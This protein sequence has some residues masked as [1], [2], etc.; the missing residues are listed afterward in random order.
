[1]AFY[2]RYDDCIAEFKAFA[3]GGDPGIE[4]LNK[5]W[6][7][8]FDHYS[9]DTCDLDLVLESVGLATDLSGRICRPSKRFCNAKVHP[10]VA[11]EPVYAV[12]CECAPSQVE[13]VGT[14]TDAPTASPPQ[15]A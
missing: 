9:V 1:M 14:Q 7:R 5:V 11:E 13:P 6:T 10:D 8:I 4:R 15:S 12:E 3:R 2:E